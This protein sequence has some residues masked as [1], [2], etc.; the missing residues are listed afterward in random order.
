M[1]HRPRLART[2]SRLRQSA[3]KNH[4]PLKAT[5][6]VVLS[7]QTVKTVKTSTLTFKKAETKRR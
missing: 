3:L 2:R 6:K 7:G 5:L 1:S 4:S